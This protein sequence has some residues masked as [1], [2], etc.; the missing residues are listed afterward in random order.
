[1]LGVL[2]NSQVCHAILRTQIFL[3]TWHEEGGDDHPPPGKDFADLLLQSLRTDSALQPTAAAVTDRQ[4]EHSNCYL[5]T[6]WADEEYRIDI[7]CL[8][9]LPSSP[10]TWCVSISRVRVPILDLIKAKLSPSSHSLVPSRDVLEQLQKHIA[11]TAGT[12]DI[13]WLSGAVY[14]AFIGLSAGNVAS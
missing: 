12:L 9:Y 8:S 3:T 14:R 10:N 11:A 5:F 6:R 2:D 13:R 4:W 7:E 1:M